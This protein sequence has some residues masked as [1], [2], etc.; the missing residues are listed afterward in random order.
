MYMGEPQSVAAIMLLCRYRAKPKS[1][2]GGERHVRRAAPR[3]GR[4]THPPAASPGLTDLDADVVGVGAAPAGVGQQD[5]LGL[6]VAV[7]DALAVQQAHG[8]RDLLQ[9]E[10]DGVL[11][12]RPHGCRESG[13]GSP[14]RRSRP[15]A[16]LG[17]HAAPLP[18]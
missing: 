11:A 10:P 8:A 15:R 3:P 18:D 13:R 6:Q 12:Q 1:A 5:V 16:L 7:D 17:L 2:A 14:A 9:E 4:P